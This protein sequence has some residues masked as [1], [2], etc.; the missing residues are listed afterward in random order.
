MIAEVDELDAGGDVLGD[1]VCDRLGADDLS[2]VGGRH[3]PRRPVQGG[4]EVVPAPPL[5]GA[6]V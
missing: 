1:E 6:G 2:A 4:P 3:E 5:G